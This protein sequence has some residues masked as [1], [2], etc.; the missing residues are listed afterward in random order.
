MVQNTVELRV[1]AINTAKDYT[2]DVDS[3][4]EEAK[5]IEKY[6]KGDATIPDVVEDPS[7]VLVKAFGE[8]QKN[9]KPLPPLPEIKVKKA[10]KKN[11][12]E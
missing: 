9:M 3:L 11:K 4:I 10:K 6:I 7:N 1:T 8:M 2:K 12:P 5:K